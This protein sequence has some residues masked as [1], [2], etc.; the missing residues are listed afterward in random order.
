MRLLLAVPCP[1]RAPSPALDEFLREVLVDTPVICDPR[2]LNYYA[3]V[4][5]NLPAMW[6]RAAA[7][8]R[9]VGVECLGRD[10]YVGVPR[11]DH[12]GFDPQTYSSYWAVPM[13]AMGRLGDASAVAR[14]IA[15]GCHG[16]DEGVSDAQA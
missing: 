4:P 8:W 12:T 2:G 6:H 1:Q 15:A 10:S 11:P 7:A 5:A 3:V 14:L 9:Y 13:A 16:L